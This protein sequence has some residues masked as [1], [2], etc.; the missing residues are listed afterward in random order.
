MNYAISAIM[1]SCVAGGAYLSDEAIIVEGTGSI[2]LAGSYLVKQLLEKVTMKQ[3]VQ[4][5]TVKSRVNRLQ[6]Q[7]RQR[8]FRQNKKHS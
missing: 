8:R 4:R 3:E 1:G 6:S 5:H 2:F 7:R